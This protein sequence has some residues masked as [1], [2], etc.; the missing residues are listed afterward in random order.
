MRDKG[1]G[2]IVD[3]IP[4]VFTRKFGIGKGVLYMAKTLSA[5]GVPMTGRTAWD[6]EMWRAVHQPPVATNSIAGVSAGTAEP[7]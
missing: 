5:R 7:G 1:L 4:F 6:L 3:S 2:Y